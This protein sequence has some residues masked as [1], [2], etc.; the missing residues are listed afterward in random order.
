MRATHTALFP[1]DMTWPARRRA[2]K[3]LIRDGPVGPTCQCA[4][5]G[6]PSA[7]RTAA[8]AATQRLI[9]L[10]PFPVMAGRKE[11]ADAS[12]SL[13]SLSLSKS[14]TIASFLSSPRTAEREA[15]ERSGRRDGEGSDISF[16][17][18]SSSSSSSS[19]SPARSHSSSRVLRLD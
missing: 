7:I 13:S 3:P 1:F 18:S 15:E 4:S 5:P 12:L 16:S 11:H 14:G 19:S 9:W 6:S 2:L 10:R 17:P 8:A